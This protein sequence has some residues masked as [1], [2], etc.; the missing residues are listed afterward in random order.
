MYN[1]NYSQSVNLSH[2]KSLI[3][4]KGKRHFLQ[5]SN[6]Y[7]ISFQI[8]AVLIEL[9]LANNEDIKTSKELSHTTTRYIPKLK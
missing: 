3:N 5:Q 6:N 9:A 4:Y 8:K 7:F 2:S 1:H